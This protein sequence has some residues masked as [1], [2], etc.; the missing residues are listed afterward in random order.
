MLNGVDKKNSKSITLDVKAKGLPTT[1]T[2]RRTANRV[3]I[4]TVCFS[5]EA[6]ARNLKM[7]RFHRI[8]LRCAGAVCLQ[9]VRRGRLCKAVECKYVAISFD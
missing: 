5:D 7:L 3:A 8:F 4:M 6:N 2:N 1:P 9:C